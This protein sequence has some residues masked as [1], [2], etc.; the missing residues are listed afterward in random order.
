MSSG[1]TVPKDFPWH[2]IARFMYKNLPPGTEIIVKEIGSYKGSGD[3]SLKEN[4]MI[5]TN[6]TDK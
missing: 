3:I 1:F 2:G 4:I 6:L 5:G